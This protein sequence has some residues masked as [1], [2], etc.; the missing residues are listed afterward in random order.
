MPAHSAES[1]WAV[2][3][4]IAWQSI[5]RLA[6]R[7]RNGPQGAGGLS[8]PVAGQ[9]EGFVARRPGGGGAL[10][11]ECRDGPTLRVAADLQRNTARSVGS[12]P[13]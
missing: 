10:R 7:V 6:A 2:V 12:L 11:G 5:L 9:L 1:S 4:I 3:P 13:V 8:P